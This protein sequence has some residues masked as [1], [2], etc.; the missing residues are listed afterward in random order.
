M[1]TKKEK[2][3]EL[4]CS[5]IKRDSVAKYIIFWSVAKKTDIFVVIMYLFM[6]YFVIS[7]A[8]STDHIVH[9]LTILNLSR[10][11]IFGHFSYAHLMRLFC[12][13]LCSTCIL[14]YIQLFSH[15]WDFSSHSVPWR[16]V[17][18]RMYALSMVSLSSH[19][20]KIANYCRKI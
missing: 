13:K 11:Q 20:V 15:G 19:F 1:W 17:E 14:F 8:R 12:L 16:E 10:W 6:F 5:R 4:I 9:N 2:L 3:H 7:W 18:V